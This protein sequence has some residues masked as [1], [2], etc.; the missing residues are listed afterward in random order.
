MLVIE[1]GDSAQDT[2]ANVTPRRL[3]VASFTSQDAVAAVLE[4]LYSGTGVGEQHRIG[5]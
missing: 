4:L 1:Y 3:L 2:G 5:P